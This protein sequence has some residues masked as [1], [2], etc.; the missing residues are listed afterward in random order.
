MQA[1]GV[2]GLD[3]DALLCMVENVRDGIYFVDPSRVIRFWSRGAERI[4][5]YP[6]AQVVGRPCGE[7]LMH[8]DESGEVLCGSRCPLQDCAVR[9]CAVEGLVWLKHAQGARVPVHVS[10]NPVVDRDGCC[11]GM[12]EVFREASEE[13]ALLKRAEELESQALLDPLTGVGNRRYAEQ[14]LEQAWETWQRYGTHFGLALLDVDHFKRVN[15]THGHKTGDEVLRSVARTMAGNL[16]A[17]DFLGRWGGEEFLAV[18][19]SVGAEDL[20]RVAARCRELAGCMGVPAAGGSVRV[21]L[22]AGVAAVE[23]CTS[24][25]ELV[26][27]ADRRLYEA[28]RVGRN[29]MA[30]P[31]EQ[32]DLV[33]VR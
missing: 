32:E 14:V 16:R 19:Q 7:Y 3:R 5:G 2:C 23:E 13:L 10:A 24:L 28:K 11:A 26:V 9:R 4:S 1:A 18:I 6:A 8:C 22:S 12:V 31:V 20:R 27:L 30:G 25:A 29:R 17:F 21:T 15:D 33:V